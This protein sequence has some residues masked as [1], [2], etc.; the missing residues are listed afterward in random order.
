M[1]RRPI[2]LLASP[3]G[4]PQHPAGNRQDAA[5]HPLHHRQRG[6]GAVLVLRDADDPGG[7]HDAVPA[8]HGQHGRHLRFRHGGGGLLPPVRG[9]GVFHPA[10]RRAALRYFPREIP[11]DPAPLR[12]LLPR[13]RGARLHGG[14]RGLEVVA[15]HRP[16]ADLHWCGRDQ[17]VCFR[18]C[19]RSVRQAQPAPNHTHFQLVLLLH[20]LRR[21]LLDGADTVAAGAP[22]AALGLRRARRVDGCGHLHVLAGAQPVRPRATFRLGIFPGGVFMG[23][24]RRTGQADPAVRLHRRLLVAL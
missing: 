19:R 17:A 13:P 24:L 5:G 22:R 18:A 3:H 21:D 7:V 11:D 6:R 15:H 16:L 12:L 2:S 10:V 8:V 14:R 20:Q 4:A 23:W 9:V 1:D